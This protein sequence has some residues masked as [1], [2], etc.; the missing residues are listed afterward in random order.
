SGAHTAATSA[1]GSGASAA[2]ARGG[3]AEPPNGRLDKMPTRTPATNT[4]PTRTLRHHGRG[5]CTTSLA[6]SAP[7]SLA[8]SPSAWSSAWGAITSAS[9]EIAGAEP[10]ASGAGDSG[11]DAGAG[12]GAASNAG[13]AA[14]SDAAV[15]T[16]GLATD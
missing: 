10:I 13:E 4:P 3:G 14:F 6:G 11:T 12:C 16:A 7:T 2:L 5:G 1:R 15:A 8:A 9:V